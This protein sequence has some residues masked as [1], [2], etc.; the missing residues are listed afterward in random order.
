MD[1]APLYKQFQY[2]SPCDHRGVANQS[3]LM[4]PRNQ[5]LGVAFLGFF[6]PFLEPYFAID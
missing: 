6:W 2:Q 4:L 1:C 5:G 3:R